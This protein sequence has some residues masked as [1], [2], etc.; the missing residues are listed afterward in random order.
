MK[1]V[2]ALVLVAFAVGAIAAAP[3]GAAA[4]TKHQARVWQRACV[5]PANG[6]ISPQPALVCAH[7]GFPMFTSAAL[8]TL[9]NTCQRDIGGRFVYRSQYPVELAACFID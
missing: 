9:R 1:R 4:P 8:G 2:L 7:H 5:G 3:V 6:E